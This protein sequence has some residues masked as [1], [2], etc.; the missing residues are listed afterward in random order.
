MYATSITMA[1]CLQSSKEKMY[2]W[3]RLKFKGIHHLTELNI[4]DLSANLSF[5]SRD[6]TRLCRAR[7]RPAASRESRD[8]RTRARTYHD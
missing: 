3:H 6:M 7:A 2:E 5:T 4:Y 1:T 8:T